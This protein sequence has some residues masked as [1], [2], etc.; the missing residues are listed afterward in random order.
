M[1]VSKLTLTFSDEFSGTSLNPIWR[2]A[3]GWSGGTGRTL[4]GN[5]EGE[6]YCDPNVPVASSGTPGI[7]PFT[8][9]GKSLIITAAPS[10]DTSSS[11]TRGL[12]YSSGMLSTWDTFV[13]PFGYWEIRCRLGTG[14][15]FWPAFWMLP[16]AIVWPWEIDAF[17]IF[18][19]PNPNKE[20]G[21]FLMH[22]GIIGGTGQHTK[23]IAS[24]W[25][26][27]PNDP[28]DGKFHTYGLD[29]QL[30]FISWYMDGVL[31]NKTPTPQQFITPGYVI[32][33]LAVG[34]N[35][36]L[37]WPKAPAA[38]ATCEM[39]I[40][41]IRIYSRFYDAVPASFAGISSPDGVDTSP[42]GALT[43]SGPV[44]V[45]TSAVSVF[46]ATLNLPTFTTLPPATF[47]V[48]IDDVVLPGTFTATA[49][50]TKGTYPAISISPFPLY[51]GRKLGV[52]FTNAFYAP[53]DNRV[54]VVKNLTFD[55]GNGYSGTLDHTNLIPS[56]GISI[57]ADGTIH[58][59]SN[60]IAEFTLPSI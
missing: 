60:V 6:Y 24:Q 59:G 32:A 23:S 41:Y 10:T 22:T 3:Y 33:N 51:G 4:S 52:K 42:V 45:G 29:W 53:P 15:G 34:T 9:T 18:G 20:G 14:S 43:S 35:Q 13:Q 50:Q 1:D 38:G 19:G 17:E 49:D 36:N 28:L 25:N 5:A 48:T 44:K 58:I 16:S 26:T 12:P 8:F 37:S 56:K 39:E 30:D 40:D 46:A 47:Q 11:G 21:H 2:T 57:A 7:N 31:V 55:C 27:V 54:L